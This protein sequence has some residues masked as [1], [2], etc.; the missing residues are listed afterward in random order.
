MT[1]IAAS[2]KTPLDAAAVA[3]RQGNA[4]GK[5]KGEADGAFAR[6]V[7]DAGAGARKAAPDAAAENPGRAIQKTGRPEGLSENGKTVDAADAIARGTVRS[8]GEQSA[9]EGN[10]ARGKGAA[11]NGPDAGSGQAILVARPVAG[12]TP[13]SEPGSDKTDKTSDAEAEKTAGANGPAQA[14]KDAETG[15]PAATG[16]APVV[17]VM[18]V[19]PYLTA[20]TASADPSGKPG[21]PQPQ[22]SAAGSDGIAA[23][24]AIDAPIGKGQAASSRA[25]TIEMAFGAGKGSRD[26]DARFGNAQAGGGQAAA[27]KIG[28]SSVEGPSIAVGASATPPA[29]GEARPSQ[30]LVVP[31]DLGRAL[32]GEG[33]LPASMREA[34]ASHVARVMAAPA[35]AGQPVSV[36]RIQLQPAH[37][38]QINVTM[39]MSGEQMTVTLTPDS[40]SAARAL[41][42]DQETIATVLRSVGG[43]FAGANIEVAGEGQLRT[44]GDDTASRSFE[45]RQGD[46]S[47]EGGR[48]PSSGGAGGGGDGIETGRG[49]AHNGP[50]PSSA[51]GRIII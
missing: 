8:E 39:R 46:R 22:R 35:M 29:G 47:G 23:G 7:K 43:S 40:A 30:P 13:A 3:E 32:A 17:A 16:P 14:T 19:A 48:S 34:V 44:G 36:L 27:V 1:Q 31:L 4:K 2:V 12:G 41:G 51:E 49:S 26:G 33:N 10:A 50:Q 11:A 28:T 45:G 5:G 38:G 9:S 25:E 6:L 24:E 20:R 18:A 21:A 42:S 15:Q 37:L